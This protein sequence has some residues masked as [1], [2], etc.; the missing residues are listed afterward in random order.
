MGI[1]T[2]QYLLAAY[3]KCVN[4]YVSWAFMRRDTRPTQL[5]YKDEMFRTDSQ[6]QG[7]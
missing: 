7:N 4:D 3:A 5:R 1:G 2:R 6:G